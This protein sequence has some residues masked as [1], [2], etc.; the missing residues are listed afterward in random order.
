ME[1]RSLLSYALDVM[2]QKV[3]NMHS[4]LYGQFS[5]NIRSAVLI[6]GTVLLASAELTAKPANVQDEISGL[7]VV[8]CLL[9][10]QLRK[11]GRTTYMT[12]RR[13]IKTTAADCNIRGGEYTAYDRANYKTALKVWMPAAEQGDP[14]AQ[15]NVGEIFEKGLGGAPN[16][17]AAL[18]W[19]TK[20]AEQGNKRGQFN[21]GTMYEQG[22]GIEKN[23]VVALNWYRKAWGLP[24]DSVM[25]QSVANEQQA[26]LR[27][28]LEDELAEKNGQL[29]LL[30][31]QIQNLEEKNKGLKS[32]QA[33]NTQQ[34]SELALLKGLV[35]GLRESQKEAKTKLEGLVLRTPVAVSQFE[36]PATVEVQTSGAADDIK[37]D[38]L[39]FGKYYALII[40]N[41]DYAMLNDLSTVRNDVK[42]LADILDKQYGFE[43]QLLLN[44][45]RLSVM[46]AV[47]ALSEKLEENDNLL[48]YYAGHGNRI[49]TG[50]REAGYWLPVNA[51]PPPD[52]SSWVPNE[53]VTNHLA[54]LKARR[55]FVISD[56]CYAGL[57]SSS[58]GYLFFAGQQKSEKQTKEYIKY[59]LP[60]RSRLL[61]TSGGD[62]PVIDN[63][64]NGHSVFATAL[65]DKLKSNNR[66]LAAPEL[67]QGIKSK[68][69][70][71]AGKYE[72]L[73]EPVY[74]SIK[75]A[76][77][78]IGD[79]FFVPKGV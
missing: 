4:H 20:A 12:A 7:Y 29:K 64:D 61:L 40:G 77:H 28:Q 58:P 11:L 30:E 5:N 72:F 27:K 36:A 46:K 67:F 10:G 31:T 35:K 55:V 44:G 70:D 22:L 50:E 59:K 73:Q 65:L 37:L 66:I 16:Y 25:F 56:S 48:I 45:D 32:T 33:L 24:E 75:G 76:G 54:R 49:S 71:E 15:V 14:E 42:Q 79:F 26:E 18:I 21:L 9:P 13:P 60:R 6:F 23:Q 2:A 74:K 8:D 19:Y 41:E 1:L 39:N 51:N 69:T 57:L 34:K 78:E 62:R 53:F 52:D 17:E 38:D 43:V 3:L 63:G 47:N 68:V